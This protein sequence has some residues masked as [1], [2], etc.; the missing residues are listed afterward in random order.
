MKILKEL[1]QNDLIE[2]EK[3]L[4]TN[5][6]DVQALLDKKHKYSHKLHWHGE[7]DIYYTM[8]YGD[9]NHMKCFIIR[10]KGEKTRYEEARAE[11]IKTS[12]PNYNNKIYMYT[13]PLVPNC[14]CIGQTTGDVEKRVKQEFKN[15]PEAPYKIL[16][17][18]DAIDKN[19][20]WFTDKDFHKY[21]KSQGFEHEIGNHSR[22]TEWYA[23][24]IKVAKKLLKQ[25]KTNK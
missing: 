13:S 21:L 2:I 10:N 14:I 5:P 25:Y 18:E 11:E 17:S 16:H 20:V 6:K 12:V 15:T 22:K 23:I 7:Q 19:G 9:I 3:R 8:E 24:D 4:L 1:H